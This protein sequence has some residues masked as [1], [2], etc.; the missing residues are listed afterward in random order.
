MYP[1]HNINHVIKAENLYI[2]MWRMVVRL[3]YSPEHKS[4]NSSSLLQEDLGHCSYLSQWIGWSSI[5]L[6]DPRHPG[7]SF[8]S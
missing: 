1:V 4:Y 8:T 5:S 2:W 3:F 6:R 7:L